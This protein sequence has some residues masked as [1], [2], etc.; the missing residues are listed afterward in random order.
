M[1]ETLERH[2]TTAN[3]LQNVLY[4]T[5]VATLF[6]D[7][8]L[9]IRFFT[10]AARSVFRVISTDIGRPLA[11]LAAVAKDDD[12][13]TDARHVLE[14]SEP[15]ERETVDDS[16]QW[17][18]R[19]IQPYRTE[20]E[21]V[22]GVVITYLDITERKRTNAAL[23]TA[24]AKAERATKA[25]SRFL[26]SASHDLRQPLQS[27]AL[28]HQLLGG[29]KRSTEGAKLA[30]LLDQTLQSMTEMLDSML[31]VN[32]IE[33]GIVRPNMRPMAIAPLM[34]RLAEEFRPQCGVKGLKLRAVPCKAWVQ[35]DPQLLEQI[36]RNLLS[37]A[38]KYT[39]KG[40]IL[41]GCRRRGGV[42]TILVCDSG[43][44]VA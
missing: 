6:L 36:L 26:A 43:I 42:L 8:D 44:G 37:N 21:K 10:P 12:L 14:T 40:G 5:D 19:R 41:M 31:D 25:K 4:S 16:G 27:M 20:G 34:Q 23:V 17:F 32:R 11:D 9:N 15:I 33:S 39:P 7:R 35:T 28:L 22:E 29:Q 38:L 13:D 30:A 2:R 1:Q 3:D 18:L 24:M